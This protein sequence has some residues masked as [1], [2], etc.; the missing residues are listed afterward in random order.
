[1][2]NEHGKPSRKYETFLSRVF[3]EVGNKRRVKFE[4]INV[5]GRSPHV[6]LLPVCMF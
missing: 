5:V 6:C 4:R 2:M 3:L 1:M